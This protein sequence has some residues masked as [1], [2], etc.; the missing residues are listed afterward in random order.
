[1][2]DSLEGQVALV[3]GASRGI[4]RAIAVQL[5]TLGAQVVINYRSNEQAAKETLSAVAQAGGR[6]FLC[7]AD[8]SRSNE[9]T[10][11]VKNVLA[12]TGQLDILVNNAGI[13]RGAL[14]HQ[15]SDEDWHEVLNTNLSAAFY[16]SRAALPAM[17]EARSRP[18]RERLLR[19]RF[20][21]AAGR[22]KLRCVQTRAHRAHTRPGRRDRLQGHPRE[23][24]GSRADRHR[25]G[26]TSG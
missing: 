11:L 4:G 2:R 14:V 21:G 13:Q 18:H 6:P 22:S 19:L 15:M 16:T 7:Q 20:H 1:M 8:V 10:A 5:S 12:Q 25:S 17:L 24:G 23:H 9:A 3:T 26:S